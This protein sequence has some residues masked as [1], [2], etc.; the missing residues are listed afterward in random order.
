MHKE[1]SSRV[2]S[3]AAILNT[4]QVSVVPTRAPEFPSSRNGFTMSLLNDAKA[5]GGILHVPG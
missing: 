1:T 2:S 3:I 5:L 4:H